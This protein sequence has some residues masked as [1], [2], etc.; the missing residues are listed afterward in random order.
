MKVLPHDHELEKS[1]LGHCI[2]DHETFL[3]C[4]STV[5]EDYFSHPFY[6]QVWRAMERIHNSGAEHDHLTIRHMMS[7]F[8]QETP[9][10][11]TQKL[12]AVSNNLPPENVENWVVFARSLSIS[13]KFIALTEEYGARAH[14]EQSTAFMEEFH[15]AFLE[16]GETKS[17]VMITPADKRIDKAIAKIE[18]GMLNDGISG[19]SVGLAAIDLVTGGWQT[20]LH[21]IAGRPGNGK[22]EIG[23][24][25]ANKV[26]EKEPAYFAQLEMSEDQGTFRQLTAVS[27]IRYSKMARSSIT[28]YE[29]DHLRVWAQRLKDNYQLHLDTQSGMTLG[30]L[31]AKIK[32]HFKKFGIKIAFVDYVQIMNVDQGKN[33]T[34][35]QALGVVTRRLKAL[36]NELDIPI[37]LFAQLGRVT[38]SHPLGRPQQNDLRES[39][40]LENDAD[41]ILLLYFAENYKN[42]YDY[43]EDPI[44]KYPLDD[45]VEFIFAKNRSGVPNLCTFAKWN[46]G[47]VFYHDVPEMNSH[48]YQVTQQPQEDAF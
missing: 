2:L 5:T 12:M 14:V 17:G 4:L 39:G 9:Q 23:M 24:Y 48:L 41:T 31:V 10:E 44:S 27:G 28:P 46:R 25:M 11:L 20:G 34:R 30:Q 47:T 33:Q 21:V 38:D 1:I 37:I 42:Q 16:L 45:I 7:E 22:T 35:D 32:Y 43:F 40:N 18:K 29:M 6:K 19:C 13:R 3:Y 26:S 36:A 15:M 8:A